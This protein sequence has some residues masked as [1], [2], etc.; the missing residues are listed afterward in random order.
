MFLLNT[1]QILDPDEVQ[2]VCRDEYQDPKIDYSCSSHARGGMIAAEAQVHLTDA[3]VLMSQRKLGTVALAAGVVAL[4]AVIAGVSSWILLGAAL[5]VW[6]FCGWAIY[7]RPR[8]RQRAAI[9]LGFALLA[10]AITAALAVISALYLLALG[11]SW[12][13]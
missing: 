11:P 8:P 6:S 10:S 1:R 5:S 9:L 13:L 7:F 2:F 4:T 12:I 3:P